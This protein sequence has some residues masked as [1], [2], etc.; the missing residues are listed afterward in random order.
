[1][2]EDNRQLDKTEM[3]KIPLKPCSRIEQYLDY[4]CK[5]GGFRHIDEHIE[6][7]KLRINDISIPASMLAII[8]SVFIGCGMA[9]SSDDDIYDIAYIFYLRYKDSWD[10]VQE[11][12]NSCV[13][14][15]NEGLV[16]VGSDFLNLIKDCFDNF[17]DNFG[18][19]SSLNLLNGLWYLGK[20]QYS[21]DFA[22]LAYE[23][24][25]KKVI[26]NTDFSV[27]AFDFKFQKVNGT[28]F[29]SVYYVYI[30]DVKAFSLSLDGG[31][32]YSFATCQSSSNSSYRLIT[33]ATFDGSSYNVNTSSNFAN[34][35]SNSID[36]PYVPGSYSWN[37][38]ES[39]KEN[40]F[41]L[42][43]VPNFLGSLVGQVT[44]EFWL[45]KNDL[46]GKNNISVPVIDNP[47]IAICEPYSFSSNS[48]NTGGQEN[49]PIPQSRIEKLLYAMA[50]GDNSSI[51]LA[52]SRIE[53]YL[54][55]I[56]TN[57]DNDLL[58]P[59]SRIEKLLYAIAT[60][61]DS[62]IEP[63]KSRIE[64]YLHYILKE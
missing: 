41:I 5:N 53:K 32:L 7:N 21:E 12:F 19:S 8:S 59:Q 3:V 46:V 40:D 64:Q 63:A 36:I 38:V 58:I 26:D 10:L 14:I 25:Y 42:L 50:T 61:D 23:M 43:P 57:D 28:T 11:T 52:E 56:L 18:N 30:N 24:G 55:Y 17:V 2:I 13:S 15:T 60:G 45:N 29:Q 6:P 62:N 44:S 48:S 20:R 47:S 4:M 51:E 33:Y 16:K 37:E 1:M 49:L 22:K 9:F 54:Y 31:Q 27:G 34:V 39:K 35:Y